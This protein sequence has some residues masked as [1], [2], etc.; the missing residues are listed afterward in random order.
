M[1]KWR[2]RT[3]PHPHPHF[4]ILM[5]K[6]GKS[7]WERVSPS[8]SPFQFED[9]NHLH[10]HQFSHFSLKKNFQNRDGYMGIRGKMCTNTPTL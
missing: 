4:N 2:R 5:G 1:E 9:E 3:S 6:L 8:S 7:G 10:P